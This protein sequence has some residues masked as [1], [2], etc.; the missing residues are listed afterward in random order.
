M[1]KTKRIESTIQ[2]FIWKITRSTD[3]I[4]YV[5]KRIAKGVVIGDCAVIRKAGTIDVYS[6]ARQPIVQDLSSH[7]VAI[8]IATLMNQ[9]TPRHSTT[10][11]ELKTIDKYHFNDIH[12]LQKQ[13][14]DSKM[15]I[16]SNNRIITTA[17]KE[18]ETLMPQLATTKTLRDDLNGKF[19]TINRQIKDLGI[20]GIQSQ[21]QGDQIRVSGKKRDTLQE[22]I[23]SLKA[24]KI[25]L[26][27]QF[28]NFRD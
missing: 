27:L 17:Q 4:K 16:E 23:T 14:N 19:R 18:I 1:G 8:C 20:K 9:Y 13:S 25:E 26:P 15:T 28:I 6:K 22:V 24:S 3:I 5:P 12:N 21:N 2:Q 11:K 10:V 7:K